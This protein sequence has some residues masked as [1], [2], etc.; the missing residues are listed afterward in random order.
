MNQHYNSYGR[1]F[2]KFYTASRLQTVIE[3]VWI[4]YKQIILSSHKYTILFRYFETRISFPC[5]FLFLYGS[6]ASSSRKNRPKTSHFRGISKAM[7]RIQN[8]VVWNQLTHVIFYWYKR[9]K[10]M[11]LCTKCMKENSG[12]HKA[13]QWNDDSEGMKRT[14]ALSMPMLQWNLSFKNMHTSKFFI[15]FFFFA[16]PSGIFDPLTFPHL[17]FQMRSLWSIFTTAT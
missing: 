1:V 8:R 9:L 13:R 17:T 14:L 6:N 15:L 2:R 10:S 16:M 11:L 4:G 5:V 7:P 12:M 3:V